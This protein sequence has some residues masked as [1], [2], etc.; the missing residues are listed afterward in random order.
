MDK[1]IK[2]LQ[3]NRLVRGVFY[4]L[5]GVLI[6]LNPEPFFNTIVYIVAAYFGVMG[7]L[8]LLAAFKTKRT[9]GYYSSSMASG[10]T[11]LIA[12]VIVLVFA[13]FI[14][15]IIPFF[16]GVIVL[17]IGIRQF[18]QELN[19]RKV[20]TSSLGWFIFSILTIVVGG[21]LVFNPFG[22]VLLIFQIFGG[23]LI[24]LAISEFIA[25]FQKRN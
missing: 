13:K 22:S 23:V 1:S 4:A 5:I 12:A 16:L 18:I 19:L 20:G 14:V 25:I 8:N 15:S 11:W 9:N 2:T 7:A 10:I 17:I 3:Q 6:L 24:F 21:V